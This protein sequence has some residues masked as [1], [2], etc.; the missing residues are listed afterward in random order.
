MIFRGHKR[1]SCLAHHWPDLT[2]IVNLLATF[3]KVLKMSSIKKG[4]KIIF[5]KNAATTNNK[6]ETEKLF[7]KSWP[8]D[9]NFLFG[10][11]NFSG[12]KNAL[13]GKKAPN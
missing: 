4:K 3:V 2:K 6:H 7:F 1:I 13:K 8:F 9:L 11:K 5:K 12:Q 10:R